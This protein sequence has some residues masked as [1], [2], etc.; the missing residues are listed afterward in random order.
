MRI[1]NFSVALLLGIVA[2]SPLRSPSDIGPP[3][4]SD[5]ATTKG[6]RLTAKFDTETTL[7]MES[8]A[9]SLELSGLSTDIGPKGDWWVNSCRCYFRIKSDSDVKHPWQQRELAKKFVLP[10]T[11]E[12]YKDEWPKKSAWQKTVR[13]RALAAPEFGH[14]AGSLYWAEGVSYEVKFAYSSDGWKSS[15]E[16]DILNQTT[17]AYAG[18]DAVIL[19]EVLGRSKIQNFLAL[20]TETGPSSTLRRVGAAEIDIAEMIRSRGLKSRFAP[21]SRL[22]LSARKIFAKPS[23]Q[24]LDGA[25]ALLN[26]IQTT[27]DA[28]VNRHKELLIETISEFRKRER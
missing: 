26:E 24:D 5:A 23:D 10:E 25:V 4:T 18:A 11:V 6:I 1:A 19:R 2:G 20:V 8:T 14:L 12:L 9:G 21:A 22:L 28:A 13:F 3:R 17:V 27:E 15:V 16:S 7:V